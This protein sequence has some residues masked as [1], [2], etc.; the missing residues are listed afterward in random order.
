[1]KAVRTWAAR[2]LLVT[3]AAAAWPQEP[4]SEEAAVRDVWKRF[5]EAR[6]GRDAKAMESLFDTHYDSVNLRLGRVLITSGKERVANYAKE[7][8]EG[9]LT[10]SMQSNIRTVRFLTADVAIMDLEYWIKE[11]PAL[12]TF[13][14]CVTLKKNGQWWIA[15][16]RQSRIDEETRPQ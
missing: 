3:F 7:F 13:L 8:A 9:R 1:M 5:V 16:I 4:P 12:K 10:N 15:A 11:T 2:T 14:T 6:N